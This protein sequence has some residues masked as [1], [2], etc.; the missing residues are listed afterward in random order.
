MKKRFEVVGLAPYAGK[1]ANDF[2]AACDLGISGGFYERK[3]VFI[4]TIA[5]DVTPEQSARQIPG[6][7]KAFE[8]LGWINVGVRE[9]SGE[10]NE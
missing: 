4:A 10:T 3:Y 2:L 7:Q 1:A 8:M 9:I 6:I 5:P